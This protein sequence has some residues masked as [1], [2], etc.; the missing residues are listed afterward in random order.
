M[1]GNPINLTRSSGNS[2][3][4][5]SPGF[6]VESN[7]AK[8]ELTGTNTAMKCPNV[9]ITLYF[10]CVHKPKWSTN[11]IRTWGFRL[12]FNSARLLIYVS[13]RTNANGSQKRQHYLTRF[14]ETDGLSS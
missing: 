6:L 14:V 12:T 13:V 2:H 10:R 8:Y 11:A 1:G 7:G 4:I 5:T 9:C 3:R